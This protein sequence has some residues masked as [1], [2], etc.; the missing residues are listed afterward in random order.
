MST[1]VL[2]VRDSNVVDPMNERDRRT[3]WRLLKQRDGDW[4]KLRRRFCSNASAQARSPFWRDQ[5][6]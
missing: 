6:Y 1:Q 5:A 4:D 2:G 3:L